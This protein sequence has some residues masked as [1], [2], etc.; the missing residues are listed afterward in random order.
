M[1]LMD[2]GLRK[3]EKMNVH[4]LLILLYPH[5]RMN[6]GTSMATGVPVKQCKHTAE[7]P[8]LQEAVNHP[9]SLTRVKIIKIIATQNYKLLRQCVKQDCRDV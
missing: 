3:T 9:K 6:T 8:D 5:C 4:V 7:Q 1:W 2:G